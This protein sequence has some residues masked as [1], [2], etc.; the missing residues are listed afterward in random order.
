MNTCN[1]AAKK[2]AR[3]YLRGMVADYLARGG[4]IRYCRTGARTVKQGVANE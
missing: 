1:T 4:K 3:D 2:P